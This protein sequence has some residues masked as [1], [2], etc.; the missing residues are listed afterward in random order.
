MFTL[1]NGTTLDLTDSVN[2]F[3]QYHQLEPDTII[4][5]L[6]WA[7]VRYARKPNSSSQGW[8]SAPT[9]PKM[10]SINSLKGAQDPRLCSEL[11]FLKSD[12]CVPPSGKR[13]KVTVITIC[14]P[15]N[16]KGMRPAI[17]AQQHDCANFEVTADDE[18]LPLWNS[19][20]DRYVMIEL[21]ELRRYIRRRSA[22]TS[23][24][25]TSRTNHLST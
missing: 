18:P 16:Y 19:P 13:H 7:K 12:H 15:N 25:R 10:M 11:V 14:S 5:A 6:P 2:T 21:N 3:R 1:D 4:S 8:A 9:V 20:F 22:V 23:E 17:R 24:T